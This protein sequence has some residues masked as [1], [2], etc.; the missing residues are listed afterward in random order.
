MTEGA[1]EHTTVMLDADR[2]LVNEKDLA[3]LNPDHVPEVSD[4]TAAAREGSRAGVSRRSTREPT[5]SLADHINTSRIGSL[6][7]AGTVLESCPRGLVV[8]SSS[9]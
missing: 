9:T 5:M 6:P 2:H 3:L 8:L 7:S 4:S 1:D